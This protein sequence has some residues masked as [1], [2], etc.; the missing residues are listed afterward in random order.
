VSALYSVEDL[1]IDIGDTRIVDGVS[2]TIDAG[3][4]VALAGASGAGKSMTAMTPFGL[5]AGVASGSVMLDGQEL[6]GLS[7]ASLRP[8]RAT[9]TGFV[10]Q[11]PL[12]AL[13]PHRTVAAHLI[14]AAMQAGGAK[15]PRAD[16]VAMLDQVGLSRA[17]ERLAQYPHR[18]SGGERQRALIAAALA[19]GPKLLIADEP[20]SALDAALR[21]EIMALLTRLCRERGMAMLLV[22]HDLAGIEHHADRLLLLEHG[23]VA[24]AGTARDVA[25]SPRSDYGQRLMAAT[26]RLTE[27]MLPLPTPGKTLLTAENIHVRFP[28]PGWARGTIQAVDDASLTLNRGETLALVG[29]SGSGK[30]TLGRAIAGLGPMQSGVIRWQ[31]DIVPPRRKRTTAHR[32]AIQPVF[33]DSLASLDPRWRVANIIAEPLQWL[34]PE[35]DQAARMERAAALLVE[36]GLDPDFGNRKPAALSGGQAQRVAIARALVADPD[37]L[38]LDEATSALDPLVAGGV[39]QLFAR[40]QSERGLSLLFITHDLAL[41]RRLAHRIAVMEAGVIVEMQTRETLFTNP[42]ANATK[43]L[44][45][46]S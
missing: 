2:F 5:S 4:I 34:M 45:A 1:R 28:K 10:F 25:L 24:E 46:A 7:E 14:E 9:K 38:L 30:S 43:K 31:G 37:M 33:Q 23:S 21:G 26:P 17:S 3:E 16:M 36:V 20:V 13:T 8:V 40:L 6:V 22:S 44:I 39:T 27:P 12:T 29:G 11:Q 15:P 32:R 18:L 35:I 42:Q 41:A 19:H